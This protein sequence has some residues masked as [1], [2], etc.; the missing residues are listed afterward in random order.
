[1]DAEGTAGKEGTVGKA[2]VKAVGRMGSYSVVDQFLSEMKPKTVMIRSGTIPIADLVPAQ[3]CTWHAFQL[4]KSVYWQRFINVSIV[5]NAI[6]IG[7]GAEITS[8]TAK[9][10]WRVCDVMFTVI[11]AAEMIV[12]LVALRLNYFYNPWNYLDFIV[13][14][15][16][17]IDICLVP[18]MDGGDSGMST[19]RVFRLLKLLRVARMLKVI[20]ELM[21]VVE[22]LVASIRAMVWICLMMLMLL[23]AAGIFCKD[24][25]GGSDAGYPSYSEENIADEIVAP[26][27]NYVY[28]GSVARSMNT[29]FNMVVLAEWQEVVRPIYE[30]Q[31]AM[32]IFFICLVFLGSFGVLNVMIGIVVENTTKA[33][34]AQ[35]EDQELE[36]QKTQIKLASNLAD[37]VFSIDV[38]SDEKISL[39][40]LE[41]ENAQELHVVLGDLG[42]PHGYSLEE[43]F[44]MLDVDGNGDL[45]KLEFV[46]G[47][48]RLI[49][50][51]QFQRD[52]LFRTAIGEVKMAVSKSEEKLRQSFKQELQETCTRLISVVKQGDSTVINID[53]VTADK[54]DKLTN[55]PKSKSADFRLS[56]P[57]PAKMAHV[58]V[59]DAEELNCSGPWNE[60][61][62]PKVFCVE[63]LETLV[64]DE[65][66]GFSVSLVGSDIAK[67]VNNADRDESGVKSTASDLT[68][69]KKVSWDRL[70]KSMLLVH[71]AEGFAID[72]QAAQNMAVSLSSSYSQKVMGWMPVVSRKHSTI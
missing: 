64:L 12:A 2:G 39:E 68:Q 30:H 9:D 7:L 32:V 17:I 33:M 47:I 19:F 35:R 36:L 58:R 63:A 70:Q 6:Q 43:L 13:A 14:N 37:M 54:L 44:V 27:N 29:L 18:F 8:S 31:P 57:V 50:C 42:L 48:M 45:S 53:D 1:M 24:I 61:I 56:E 22:G 10:V 25:I 41:A 49:Y 26:F 15:I 28:F 3:T 55:T 11:F 72:A 34:A 71:Q 69:W 16:A 23:Y 40:E 46:Q 67:D 51:N 62:S 4:H 60:L 20:P 65:P 21:M 59:V 52:C 66:N 5:L 38:N